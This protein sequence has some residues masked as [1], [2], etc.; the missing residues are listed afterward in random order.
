MLSHAVYANDFDEEMDEQSIIMES[1]NLCCVTWY[2]TVR[3]LKV[4]FISGGTYTYVDVPRWLVR[5][6]LLARS[7]GSFFSRYIRNRFTWTTE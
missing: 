1:S 7:A 5:K 3:E 4:H 6:M 2:D